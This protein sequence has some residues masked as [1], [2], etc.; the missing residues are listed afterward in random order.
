LAARSSHERLIS[1]AREFGAKAICLADGR[2]AAQSRE[3]LGP[4]V[5]VYEGVQG[6][7]DMVNGVEFD[8][9]VN[10]L[11]GSAGL[12]PTVA[13][14]RRGKRVALAN[15]ESLV[16]GGELITSLLDLGHGELVPVDSE[17]SAVWQCLSGQD[18]GAVESIILTASGGPFRELPADRFAAIT[19]EQALRHPT[20]SMGDKITIDCATLV[21]KGLEVIEA[22][23]L[24]RMPY[25]HL[26]VLIHPQSIVH[27]MVEFH[28]GA[29]IAQ[30]GL[31]DM[32]LPIQYALEYPRRLPLVGRRLDLTAMAGLTFHA[33]DYARFPC[34]RL[35]LDAGT[36]GGTAPAALNA[37][38]E[39]AVRAFLQGAIPFT[40]IAQL[41]DEALQHHA[42]RKA[43]SLESILEVDGRVREATTRAL[44]RFA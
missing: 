7:L 18:R 27:S 44:G 22:H 17:H 5:R 14:L 33:P 2:A 28:D 20:W 37:A 10:A 6:L 39:V 19:P 25:D 32:E 21:N 4:S 31:P 1:Q 30:M 43:D 40:A 3:A 35:C 9:L 16:V 42:P 8:V 38:N 29:I 34:L 15:K 36:S 24:F 41:I 26:R 13:A 23:H 11:V 12:A